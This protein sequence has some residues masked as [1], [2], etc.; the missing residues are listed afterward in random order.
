MATWMSRLFRSESTINL[1]NQLPSLVESRQTIKRKFR[2]SEEQLLG[3][4]RLTKSPSQL[5][6]TR[7][8]Q[9]C[10]NAN[11]SCLRTTQPYKGR[12]LN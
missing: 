8:M 10:S 5:V 1:L 2:P 4:E 6:E 12:T 7:I 11:L 9:L 3:D